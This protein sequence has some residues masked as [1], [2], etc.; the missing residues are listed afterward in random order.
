MRALLLLLGVL[1]QHSVSSNTFGLK[2]TEFE[3]KVVGKK[4]NIGNQLKGLRFLDEKKSLSH[5]N[6]IPF[7]R[8]SLSTSYRFH[9]LTDSNQFNGFSSVLYSELSTGL[10]LGYEYRLSESST[11]GATADFQRI[12]FERTLGTPLSENAQSTYFISGFYSHKIWNYLGVELE[13]G[14]NSNVFFDAS[15]RAQI[16][17]VEGPFM[18]VKLLSD[19]TQKN[20]SNQI[21]S[22]LELSYQHNFAE[23]LGDSIISDN[24]KYRIGLNLSKKIVDYNFVLGVFY[25]KSFYRVRDSEQDLSSFGLQIGVNF[26]AIN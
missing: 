19:L 11:L 18:G 8:W 9:T 22:N 12:I 24:R 25:S 23:T 13:A 21:S 16:N 1:L 14:Y 7:H 5:T 15:E 20:G 6:D 2:G 3:G 10:E 4:R 26:G 17:T